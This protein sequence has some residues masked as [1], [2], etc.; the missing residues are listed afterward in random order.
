[1]FRGVEPVL[2]FRQETIVLP[3]VEPI[4][5][6]GVHVAIRVRY[7]EPILHQHNGSIIIR[8]SRDWS[9]GIHSVNIVP[10]PNFHAC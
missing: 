9:K 7:S 2:A 10:R 8:V 3:K 6:K 4:V 1:M 5:T